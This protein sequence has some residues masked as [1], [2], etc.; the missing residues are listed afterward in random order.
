MLIEEPDYKRFRISQEDL[1]VEDKQLEKCD[2]FDMVFWAK[3]RSSFNITGLVHDFGDEF[4]HYQ[5]EMKPF[6]IN[7]Y[8]DFGGASVDG[9]SVRSIVVNP[10][11]T[12]WHETEA[13]SSAA[14]HMYSADA[15]KWD[16]ATL[17]EHISQEAGRD[18]YRAIPA[19][20]AASMRGGVNR[21]I[22]LG[23][24][25]PTENLFGL[26]EREDTLVLGRTTNS[27]AYEMWAFDAPHVPDFKNGLYGNQPF[28]E[29]IGPESAQAITWVN[30]AH[31]WVFLD[32]ATYQGEK[33]SHIN[34]VSETGALELFLF[35][36]SLPV[37][38]GNGD[39][40]RN[41]RIQYALGTVT[42]FAPMPPMH[43]L[44]FMFSKYDEVSADIMR[45]RNKNFTDT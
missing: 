20:Q 1:P 24:F 9:H 31:T 32:D 6:R 13:P 19:D 36:S 2:L 42:G 16:V 27:T 12:L 43:T 25:M 33:G 5:V 21:G 23:F 3:D 41:K 8:S 22:G 7:Q 35:S 28:V 15:G 14:P 38:K 30:S 29:G 26:G 11:D 17:K 4:F 39:L 18:V 44:G 34:F 45:A 37:G 10:Q 40:N